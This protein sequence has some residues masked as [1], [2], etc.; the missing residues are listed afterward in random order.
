[1]I[2]RTASEP[3]AV[4]GVI[5]NALA[6]V[7]CSARIGAAVGKVPAGKPATTVKPSRGLRLPTLPNDA[8][9]PV[10]VW[11]QACVLPGGPCRQRPRCTG[12]GPRTTAVAVRIGT[13]QVLPTA[14][15]YSS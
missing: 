11:V 9:P 1:M 14:F 10:T 2:A 8:A 6:R 7:R 12:A 3:P 5:E 13:S 4:A 15:Q